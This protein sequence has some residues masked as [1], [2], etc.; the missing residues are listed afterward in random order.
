MVM[1]SAEI[2]VTDS[3]LYIII[4]VVVLV[5]VINLMIK[6]LFDRLLLL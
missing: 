1:R 2:L 4:I 6:D 5:V 3:T